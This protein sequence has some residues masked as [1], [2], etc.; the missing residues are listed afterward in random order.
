LGAEALRQ[1]PW[2]EE[3][4]AAGAR[5]AGRYRQIVIHQICRLVERRWGALGDSIE[6]V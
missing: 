4:R 5:A 1:L 6:Q 3:H 2:V